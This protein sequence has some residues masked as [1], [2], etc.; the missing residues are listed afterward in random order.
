[1]ATLGLNSTNVGSALAQLL[2][3]DDIQ[4]GDDPSY[5]LC[6]AIYSYHPLGKKL[7]DTPIALAQS[8]PREISVP[9][10]PDRVREK[11][12]QQW[13]DDGCDGHIFN[14]GSL[15]RIYG[16]ASVALLAKKRDSA[17]QIPP[18]EAIEFDQLADLDVAFSVLDPLNTAGSLVG[19]L[20]PNSMGFLKTTSIAV[21]GR[22]YHRSR[23]VTLLNEK[24]IYLEYTT[25]AFGYVGRS[26]Y[27]RALFPLKSYVKTM[28]TNDMV[29]TKAGVIVAKMK[30][31]GSIVSNIMQTMF[32]QK[33]DIVKEAATW[34]VISITPEEGIESID[35]QNVNGA[36]A[37]SRKNILNDTAV[38]ADMPAILL[39]NETYANGFGEGTEDANNVARYIK[40]VRE[41]L[42]HVYDW[43]DQ[44]T[45]YRAW[46]QDF[47]ATIQ[48]EFPDEY[49][50]VRYETAFQEWRNSF[51]FVWP[52]LIQEPESEEVKVADVKLKAIIAMV[53]VLAPEL[54]PE[55]K[56][57]LFKWAADNFNEI[58]ALFTVPLNLDFG[59]LLTEAEKKAEQAESLAEAGGPGGEDEEGKGPPP[60]RPFADEQHGVRR[61]GR[62]A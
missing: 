27:Q 3:A 8:E 14:L 37:E 20:N 25:S 38:A 4:P 28:I 56:V 15:S 40:G 11:F 26:V 13:V 60:P 23:S 52:S 61:L 59:A 49:G 6:K 57:E 22:R 36:M 5:Q 33:R 34:N 50:S 24:P 41:E 58:E 29:A 21:S 17:E 31:A 42:R 53:Q 45:M 44:I 19:D 39:N 47:Y 30:P 7:T 10:A 54:D 43:F 46:N 1:M 62:A 32:G 16:V 35:L 18:S 2:L 48:E 55:N 12:N 9:V 51:D